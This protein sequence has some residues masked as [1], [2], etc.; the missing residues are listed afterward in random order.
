MTDSPFTEKKLDGDPDAPSSGDHYDAMIASVDSV[1][2][3]VEYQIEKGRIRDPERDKVRVKQYRALG[4][5]L[6]TKQKVLRDRELAE[7]W[8]VI[9]ELQAELDADTDHDS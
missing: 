3:E 9:E 5:L 6:R 4:Y 8:E 1:I 2:E 7:M